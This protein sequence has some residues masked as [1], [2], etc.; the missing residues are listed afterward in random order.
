MYGI[1]DL[2]Q[3]KSEIF[4]DEFKNLIDKAINEKSQLFST[5]KENKVED[6]DDS[7]LLRDISIQEIKLQLDRTKGRSAPGADGI[8]Y[9]IIKKCPEIVFENLK[10]MYNQCL[11][12]GYFPSKWKEAQGIMLPKPK[13]DNKIPTNYRPISLL[14][15]IGKLF[16]KIIAHRMRSKLEEENFLFKWQ[17]GYRNKRCAM[18]HILRL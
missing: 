18:E 1:Y 2:H 15:C 13:K 16:E 3:H 12:I 10:T 4:D 14:S 6:G 9:T 11:K 5:L 17:I 8:K 7:I